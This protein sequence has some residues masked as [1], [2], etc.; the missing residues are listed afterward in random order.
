MLVHPILDP[1]PKLLEEACEVVPYPEG[2][3]LEEQGIR[4]AAEGC[5]GILSQVMDPIGEEVL[6]TPGLKVVSNVAVG[7]DNIDVEA[8]TRHGV[9]VTNTPGVLTSTT[10][11][12]AFA[13]LMAAARR[14][15]D[16][17]RYLRAGRFKGW[18]IDMMLGQD[19]HGATLGLVG[20]GRIGGAVA[21]RA[22][23]FDMRILY[24][25]SVALPPEVEIELGAKRVHL[26]RLLEESDFVSLHVPLTPDTHHLISTEELGR[27]KSTAV[28]VNTS[29]G[30]VVDEEALATALREGQ[31][32]AAALDVFEHEPE[33]HPA[34]LELDNVVLTPHIASASGRT[35][36]EMCEM[37]VKDLIAGLRGERPQNLL[38]PEVLSR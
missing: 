1:G 7:Y 33:V 30:P 2:Q 10:A 31:I 3:P 23:G 22:R 17:D 27:M 38:N 19:L 34:L 11:D 21:R 18:A 32:F 36:S 25:D 35:R 28:L 4:R 13:L 5:P 20:V 8:A 37:A 26:E 29:R 6:S 15:A 9:L 14:V 12:F 16:G 24:S